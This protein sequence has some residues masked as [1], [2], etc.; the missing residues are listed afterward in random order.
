MISEQRCLPLPSSFVKAPN[1]PRDAN[2]VF[3]HYTKL[4]ILAA[5][6]SLPR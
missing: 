1:N 4:D 3:G 6:P 2:F 5:N